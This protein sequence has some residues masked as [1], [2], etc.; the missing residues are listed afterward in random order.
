MKRI[1]LLLPLLAACSGSG[2][3]PIASESRIESR[4]HLQDLSYIAAGRDLKTEV[5]GNPFSSDQATFAAAVADHLQGVNPGPDI[6]FTPTPAATAR[7][8]YFVRLVF[9]GPSASNGTQLCKAA[10]DVAPSSAPSGAVRLIGA[11][12]RGDQPMTYASARSGG[13]T[14][15]NDPAFR[16]LV[17]Q[18]GRL[19]FPLR[20][21]EDINNCIPPNC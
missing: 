5:I 20:N 21:P 17:R 10:P 6:H 19:L 11:F 16:D 15:V 2:Q 8:P 1:L 12:C 18:V 14:D 4:Y 7:E 13:I 3:V 9:N